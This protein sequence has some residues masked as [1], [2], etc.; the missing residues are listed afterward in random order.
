MATRPSEWAQPATIELTLPSGNV[1]EVRP[2]DL[3]GLMMSSENQSIP[4]GLLEQIGRQI[5][6]LAPDRELVCHSGLRLPDV[7]EPVSQGLNRGL[8]VTAKGNEQ[9]FVATV[10]MQAG[11][12]FEVGE[13]RFGGMNAAIVESERAKKWTLAD[14]EGGDTAGVLRD[15]GAFI[16][17]IA[18]A[19]AV[20]PRWVTEVQNPDEEILISRVSKADRMFV[21]GWA[22][23]SEVRPAS[24]FPAES[25]ASLA[26]S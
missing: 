8:V 20:N 2:I 17:L 21:F 11:D 14:E 12:K 10:S 22:M 26:A 19:A 24:T 3:I 5:S 4:N 6:G 18:R 9:Y 7:G 13:I 16:D 1:V 25:T 15:M 23:P